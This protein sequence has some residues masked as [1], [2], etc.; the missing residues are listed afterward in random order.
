MFYQR[1]VYCILQHLNCLRQVYLLSL[2][3]RR[4]PIECAFS[5]GGLFEACF[6][7]ETR[8]TCGR[9]SS[10]RQVYLQTPGFCVLTRGEKVRPTESIAGGKSGAMDV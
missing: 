4:L 7:S 2:P 8:L 3:S 1:R 10:Y 9:V 6:A 5:P